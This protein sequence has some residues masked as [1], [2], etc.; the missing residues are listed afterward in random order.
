MYFKKFTLTEEVFAGIA[1]LIFK[2]SFNSKA[3]LIF[4][5]L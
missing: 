5:N 2:A 1:C 3:R 4:L